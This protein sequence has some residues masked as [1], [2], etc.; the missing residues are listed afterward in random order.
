M[1]SCIK[2]PPSIQFGSVSENINL[3]VEENVSSTV[4]PITESTT[5]EGVAATPES[6]KGIF[7]NIGKPMLIHSRR[8]FLN[9]QKSLTV[10]VCLHATF[11]SL[12]P[13]LPPS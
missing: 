2:I 11:F 1:K 4:P 7:E 8:Y 5:V 10:R 12:C 6:E 13:L 3:I 9:V